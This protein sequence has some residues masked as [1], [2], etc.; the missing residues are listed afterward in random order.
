MNALE[1]LRALRISEKPAT[2]ALTKLPK[3]P[4]VSFGSGQVGDISENARP[5]STP[6]P[7]SDP[8]PASLNGPCWLASVAAH[9]DTTSAELLGAGVILPDEVAHYRDRDPRAM[10]DALRRAHLRRFAARE[11]DDRRHC[12][13]CRNLSG[14]RCKA[15]RLLV[16][17]NLPRRCWHYA[18]MPN[19][20]DQRSGRERWPG[21]LDDPHSGQTAA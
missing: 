10:A 20:V 14:N 6:K 15:R 1:R 21:L 11:P 9:L 2:E 17:D 16:L 4:F 5:D 3:D 7:A 12:A 18:P 13:T 19:D 8:S